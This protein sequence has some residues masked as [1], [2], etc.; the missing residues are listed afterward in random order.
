MRSRHCRSRVRG[1]HI[2]HADAAGGPQEEAL[3][4]LE[5]RRLAGAV[6][7]QEGEH[8]AALDGEVDATDRFERSVSLH[9][10]C[11][12]DSRHAG[13]GTSLF[14]SG[15]QQGERDT[16]NGRTVIA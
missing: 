11:D 8:L 10:T 3:E 7:P 2:E 5:G 13:D 9:E 14:N 1:I 15:E 4:D 6:G 12:L 16:A